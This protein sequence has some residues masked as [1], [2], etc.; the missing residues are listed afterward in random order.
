[1]S[2]LS[3][4]QLRAMFAKGILKH[5]KGR[6]GKRGKVIYDRKRDKEIK[7]M[8]GKGNAGSTYRQKGSAHIGPNS[9]KNFAQRAN[10]RNHFNNAAKSGPSLGKSGAGLKAA[11]LR[12]SG[13][14]KVDHSA[15]RA[16][17]IA[18][19]ENRLERLGL[20]PSRKVNNPS[21]QGQYG[22]E[23]RMATIRSMRSSVRNITQ[24]E[25]EMKAQAKAEAAFKTAGQSGKGKTRAQRLA[26]ANTRLDLFW[27]TTK[28]S[29]VADSLNHAVNVSGT[30]SPREANRFRIRQDK[31]RQT[32]QSIIA[33]QRFTYNGFKG[34]PKKRYATLKRRERALRD[35]YG[36]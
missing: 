13:G 19:G 29:K 16:A 26:D 15:T 10:S 1:M 17:R 31:A 9:S 6:G 35:K 25:R 36:L 22:P 2:G 4:D 30:S 33:A 12:G 23:Q 34:D 5:G 21:L 32:L 7:K 27:N 14:A 18:A 8:Q 11:H 20:S 24:R 3:A 28:G